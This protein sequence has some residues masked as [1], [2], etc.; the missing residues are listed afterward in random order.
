M[1]PT[2]KGTYDKGK[3]ILDEIP[4]I[5]DNSK[6]TVVLLEEKSLEP[7]KRHLGNLKGK[8]GI[9]EDFNEPLEDLKDYM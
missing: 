5:R 4:P 3:I 8:I 9:P 6:V 7:R 1:L 2:V